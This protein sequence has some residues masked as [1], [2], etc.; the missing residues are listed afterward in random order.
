MYTQAI[1]GWILIWVAALLLSGWIGRVMWVSWILKWILPS[2]EPKSFWRYMFII[3]LIGWVLV[4]RIIFPESNIE[5]VSSSYIEYIIAGILVW[6][7]V[8]LANGCTSGHAVCGIGRLSI[9]SIT[10]TVTFMLTGVITVYIIT[11][12]L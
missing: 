8:S 12:L 11:H 3:G 10:A 7:W 6:F 5:L 2:P 1:I 4:Y 9:R